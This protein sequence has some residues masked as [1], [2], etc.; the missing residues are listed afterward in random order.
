MLLAAEA[1]A[2]V[3]AEV[4]VQGGAAEIARGGEDVLADC[5]AALAFCAE[6][7]RCVVLLLAAEAPRRQ[8]NVT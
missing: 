5:R 6:E 3:A 1:G 7:Q 2:G 4:A 8:A